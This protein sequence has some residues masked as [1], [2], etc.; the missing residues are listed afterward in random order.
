MHCIERQKM[1]KND[2]DVIIKIH[3]EVINGKI[4]IDTNLGLGYF[5]NDD[6]NKKSFIPVYD[7]LK[8][9]KEGK[10][11]ILNKFNIEWLSPNLESDPSQDCVH[12]GGWNPLMVTVR[13]RDVQFVGEIN[14]GYHKRL[15]D[16]LNESKNHFISLLN[17]EY[18]GIKRTI[19]INV[20]SIISIYDEL[21]I[22]HAEHPEPKTAVILNPIRSYDEELTAVRHPYARTS[23]VTGA[24][25]F[26]FKRGL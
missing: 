16:R 10:T 25:D 24:N 8:Q 7:S 11:I 12:A 19:F 5:F 22:P 1:L 23:T 18:R 3:S 17:V 13:L 6:M 4:N 14:L 15:S 9:G 2:I 21:S 20:D 26:V